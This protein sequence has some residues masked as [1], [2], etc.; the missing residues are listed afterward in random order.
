MKP[1]VRRTGNVFR[2]QSSHTER[3]EQKCSVNLMGQRQPCCGIS[4]LRR[5]IS[6]LSTTQLISTFQ[7]DDLA[8]TALD[9]NVRHLI[10]VAFER[11]D[12]FGFRGSVSARRGG[13][14]SGRARNWFAWDESRKR[15][16]RGGA[17]GH[18]SQWGSGATLGYGDRL[19]RAFQEWYKLGRHYLIW[20][21]DLTFNI[22]VTRRLLS[23]SGSRFGMG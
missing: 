21:P 13:V 7:F 5:V 14:H 10:A 18:G 16:S 23:L 19:H 22:T 15:S 8:A 11:H 4:G 9:V 20:L 3:I 6:F 2:R 17:V 1:K 12:R